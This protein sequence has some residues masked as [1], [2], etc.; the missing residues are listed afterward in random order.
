MNKKTAVFAIAFMAFGTFLV[1]GKEAA[2]MWKRLYAR[3]ATM[4][5]RYSVMQNLIEQDDADIVPT[6]QSALDELVR[7]SSGLKTTTD[8]ESWT[9]LCRLIVNGLGKMKATEAA[10]SLYA[11]FLT[12]EN[13]VLKADAL[14]AVGKV[15]GVEFVEPISLLLKNLNLNQGGDAQSSEIIAYGC[16][17]ALE[18]LRSPAGYKQVF[19]AMTGWYSQ[20][21]KDRAMSALPN[22][23][24]DPSDMLS[25]I[26]REAAPEIKLQALQ[27]SEASQ[28]PSDKKIALAIA[29]LEAGLAEESQDTR[30][31]VKYGALRAAAIDSLIAHRSK[32]ESAVRLLRQAIDKNY[33]MNE[34]LSAVTAL[35]V[36]GSDAATKNLAELMDGQNQRQA[37]GIPDPD[38]RFNITLMRAL[39]ATRN[40]LAR[41][42]LLAVEFSNYTPAMIR[43]SREAL[44]EID[45]R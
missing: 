1:S 9:Q 35:G 38:N 3:A 7:V 6:L 2:E 29:A 37:A 21:V 22:I 42:V 11:C 25:E 34:K 43:V 39:G 10:P 45:K 26:V 8:R 40:P 16:I 20:R 32:N 15:K 14:T 44:Q 31:N 23:V 4:E 27:V 30:K 5:Q 18:K 19:F 12:A 28:A 41:P 36:V 33:D 24:S 13:P 17:N